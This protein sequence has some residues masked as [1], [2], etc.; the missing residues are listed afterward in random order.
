MKVA[1]LGA[2][3]K[4][5]GRWVVAGL[6]AF[7]NLALLFFLF[8]V[9]PQEVLDKG[10]KSLAVT[11]MHSYMYMQINI[12]APVKFKKHIIYVLKYHLLILN[13]PLIMMA[14]IIFSVLRN[15]SIKKY[16]LH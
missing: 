15:I 5:G 6:W 8:F 13:P 2:G 3:G 9:F 11:L 10:I 4:L 14:R 7:L 16:C 1:Y 12:C